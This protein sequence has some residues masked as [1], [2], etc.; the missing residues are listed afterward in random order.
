MKHKLFTPGPTPL[1]EEVRL[2]Q[3]RGIIHHRSKEFSDVFKEIREELKYV[4]QT[5]EEVLLFSSSGT[6]AMEAV[7]ANLFSPGDKVLVIRG[8]KFG[9]RWAEIADA[10]SLKVLSIDLEWGHVVNPELI[11]KKLR[12]NSGIKAVFTQLVETSTGVV[13]DIETIARVT[14][15]KG[16]ILIV[17]AVSGLG[18]ETLCTDKW[19]VD[20]VMAG[21][22]KALMIPPGL[23]FVALSGKAW[24]LIENSNLPKY[25]WDFKKAKKA[26]DKNQTVYTPAITLVC[27][28]RESLRLLKKE[29]WDNVL[30]RHAK[31]AKATR[32]GVLALGLKIFSKV[33]S[34]VLTAVEIPS[35]VGVKRLR[36]LMRDRYGVEVA[37]GQAALAEKIIRIAHLGAMEVTD[38]IV[39]LSA[40]EM[41]LS[42]LG[43]PVE[44]GKG[45]AAAEEIL[46]R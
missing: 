17:D 21:S 35:S 41:S 26:Q 25:Y 39:V 2:I 46:G 20:V 23:A 37:G 10:F 40:L 7:V 33:P 32:Q 4:F 30:G 27:A 22:Q 9:E 11:E 6:G 43:Y 5:K 31:L 44:M 38:I 29:G 12:E 19:G 45:I 13:Y 3:A 18:A 36:G 16:V 15:G 8:G 42:E 14:K 1:P 24:K 28:L 34:N